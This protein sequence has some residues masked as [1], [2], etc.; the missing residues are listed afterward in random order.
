MRGRGKKTRYSPQHPHTR[1]ASGTVKIT[2]AQC[3]GMIDG[4]VSDSEMFGELILLNKDNS[5]VTAV[6]EGDILLREWV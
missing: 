6:A 4:V 3:A 2:S 1:V 5:V